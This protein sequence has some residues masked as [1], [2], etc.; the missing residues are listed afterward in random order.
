MRV[1]E[2]MTKNPA[3]LTADQAVQEAAIMMRERDCGLLPVVQGKDGP[4]VGVVTDRDIA[5]R[6]IAEGLGAD[7]PVRTAM[8]DDPSCCRADDDVSR[9]KDIM[10][11]RRVRRVPVIDD[12]GR[13]VGIVA[14]ADLL[15]AAEARADVSQQEVA[16]VLER[17]SEPG[18]SPRSKAKIGERPG[19]HRA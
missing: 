10:A 13:C 2:L 7:T 19:E 1:Q 15:R 18:E 9:L 17:V 16:R 6:V 5:L 12:K 14:Q 8:S 3:C 11:E 4:I